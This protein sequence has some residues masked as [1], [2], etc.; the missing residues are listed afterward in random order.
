MPKMISVKKGSIWIVRLDKG[1]KI[2]ASLL[3]FCEQKKISGGYFHGIGALEEAELAHYALANKKS[4]TKTLKQPLEIVHLT[5][6]IT[7]LDHKP[8]VHAHIVVSDEEMHTFGGHLKEAAVGPTG[9]I[10]L[11]P[12]PDP[13]ERK[14][15]EEIGLN[16]LDL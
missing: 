14:F 3:S 6:N 10:V 5:G 4:P 2:I 1:D 16:L 11:I 8:Y 13:V 9:E 15:S 7:E 12:L